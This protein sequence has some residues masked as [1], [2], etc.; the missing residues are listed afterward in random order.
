MLNLFNANGNLDEIVFANRN[1]AYGAYQ[2]RKQYDVTLTKAVFIMLSAFLLLFLFGLIPNSNNTIPTSTTIGEGVVWVDEEIVFPEIDKPIIEE[3]VS[4]SSAS[5][6]TETF[7]IAP[8]IKVIQTII[9]TPSTN[10]F[11]STVSNKLRGSGN[12]NVLGNLP[13]KITTLANPASPFTKLVEAMPVFDNGQS[14]LLSYLQNNIQYP[15]RAR[16]AQ[17]GGKVIVTFIVDENGAVSDIAIEK[18]IGYGCDEEAIRVVAEMPKWKPAMQ[19]GKATA[20]H[21]RL[22]IQ[23]AIN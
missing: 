1:K 14:E 7:A 4:G 12:T 10:N 8:D 2:I 5:K 16:M 9:T 19:N 18:G 11:P 6:T 15:D 20:I 21:M 17:V 23:F 22:P 3:Q 13:G